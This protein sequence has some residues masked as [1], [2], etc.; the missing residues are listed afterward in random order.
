MNNQQRTILNWSL[1][2]IV[3]LAVG[4]SYT[5]HALKIPLLN[6]SAY[7]AVGLAIGLAYLVLTRLIQPTWQKWSPNIR[8]GVLGA[9]ILLAATIVLIRST[10]NFQR[11]MDISRHWYVGPQAGQPATLVVGQTWGETVLHVLRLHPTDQPDDPNPQYGPWRATADLSGVLDGVAKRLSFQLTQPEG[12]VIDLQTGQIGRGDGVTVVFKVERAGDWQTVQRVE[13]NL[14][15]HPDQR[16]W[17]TVEVEV[18]ADSQRLAIE[19]L[20]GPPGSNIL[21]D[22]VWIS[23]EQVSPIGSDRL[24]AS[25]LSIADLIVLSFLWLSGLVLIFALIEKLNLSDLTQEDIARATDTDERLEKRRLWFTPGKL[26]KLYVLAGV[27]IAIVMLPV[28]ISL[29]PWFYA[30]NTSVE[31]NLDAPANTQMEICWDETEQEC[32][33]LVP[34]PN[35]DEENASLWLAEL[36]PRP[37]Y[38]L[39]LIFRSPVSQVALRGLTLQRQPFAVA[40]TGAAHIGAAYKAEAERFIPQNVEAQYLDGAAEGRLRLPEV[41]TPGPAGRRPW[42]T[43]TSVWLLLVGAW[44]IIGGVGLPL[45]RQDADARRVPLPLFSNNT[46]ILWLAFGVATTIHLLL[47]VNSAVIFYDYDEVGYMNDART[48][49][50]DGMYVSAHRLPGYLLLLAMFFKL[51]GYHLSTVA[52]LQAAMFDGA[53][54]ALAWS[55]RRWLQPVVG[56]IGILVAILSP[57][58]VQFS[59]RIMSESAFATFAMFSLAALFAHIG[60]Q[61]L[62]SKVWLMLYAILATFAFL[63]RQN[64]I[65]LFAALI[66]VCL[67][68]VLELFWRPTT[69][70]SKIRSIVRY[71]IPYFLAVMVL[72]GVIIGWS[73]RNYLNYGYFQLSMLPGHVP[74]QRLLFAGILEARGLLDIDCPPNQSCSIVF[75]H[76]LYDDFII[77][78]YQHA[79]W[80]LTFPMRSTI[81]QILS[82]SSSQPVNDF[83]ISHALKEIGDHAADLSPWPARAIG[84]LRVGWAAFG[85]RNMQGGFRIYPI[86]QATLEQRREIL[87]SRVSSKLIYD[88]RGE[89]L[90]VSL[91][92]SIAQGYRWHFPLW[93]L[94]LLSGLTMLWRR[95]PILTCPLLVFMANGILYIYLLRAAEFRYIQIL[96]TFLVFQC[97]LGLSLLL[98]SKLTKEGSSS[99]N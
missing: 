82:E 47:V 9:S 39:A 41:I 92:S 37:A 77:T 54:L 68:N 35:P 99:Q 67:P 45:L 2:V 87:R 49:V 38:Q 4:A 74:L 83:Q 98:G 85:R 16:H 58:Q 8:W 59:M 86:D 52:L 70:L 17:H 71:S 10:F 30:A 20:P 79:G 76:P 89:S 26:F 5:I 18:P 56:A 29:N 22:T 75:G 60:S 48:L 81:L 96:D 40:L 95:Q 84:L 42:A 94:A 25:L 73:A 34:Y 53:V 15:A 44:L 19:A 33:P 13:L 88:E 69:L 12:G 23:L 80:D 97:A 43:V 28:A 57:L 78:R 6:P 64:G 1:S 61:G 36:P 21:W 65:V 51:F 55:L 66:P 3:G 50:E 11:L 31:L 63:I 62:R 14:I 91:Y 32:L 90:L 27:V 46:N 7:V 72:A 93:M 24:L